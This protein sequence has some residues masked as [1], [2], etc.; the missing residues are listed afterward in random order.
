MNKLKFGSSSSASRTSGAGG[1]E[2][3]DKPKKSGNKIQ[4]LV[5]SL[6]GKKN[7]GG[8]PPRQSLA[9]ITALLS[10]S[11][12]AAD[13]VAADLAA[14][15]IEAS[16][17]AESADKGKRPMLQ[18][19][20]GKQPEKSP[21][22]KY[23]ERFKELQEENYKLVRSLA[24]PGAPRGDFIEAARQLDVLCTMKPSQA[25]L[26]GDKFE[27]LKWGGLFSHATRA[28]QYDLL[29]QWMRK[30]DNVETQCELLADIGSGLS[31]RPSEPPPAHSSASCATYYLNKLPA[32]VMQHNGKPPSPFTHDQL[33]QVMAAFSEKLAEG[34][35]NAHAQQFFDNMP[36]NLFHVLDEMT[37]KWAE[38][39]F[40]GLNLIRHSVRV[41][42]DY[43][44]SCGSKP[45]STP[46][47][48]AEKRRAEMIDT[49]HHFANLKAGDNGVDPKAKIGQWAMQ[50]RKYEKAAHEISKYT[51]RSASEMAACRDAQS[52]KR[53][54]MDISGMEL[55]NLPEKF[56]TL[57]YF[58]H[59]NLSNNNI[60][61][62]PME[63][64]NME[65]FSGYTRKSPEDGRIQIDL[66]GNPLSKMTLEELK[67]LDDTASRPYGPVFT[68]PKIIQLA[69]GN[70]FESSQALVH[71][72]SSSRTTS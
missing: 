1:G 48:S 38:A 69:D 23:E 35:G 53:W 44:I 20:R 37:P 30:F 52:M 49:C 67:V 12:S 6:T 59:M 27:A 33:H 64:A 45:R 58:S 7:K 41:M 19:L 62:I 22:E 72:G 61:R 17:G 4:Q 31:E 11:T 21:E 18:R 8:Q 66:T 25:A 28:G 16:E 50:G 71:V 9:Q 32:L 70:T 3:P 56:H 54:G 47:T 63:M 46:L 36:M 40:D 26:H 51:P 57:N 14:L 29:T 43:E 15:G 55:D 42:T 5:G 2:D 13:A 34:S 10:S 68:L 24:E 60:Q 39:T 65:F